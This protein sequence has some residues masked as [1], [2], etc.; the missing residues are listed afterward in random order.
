[1]RKIR[2]AET[3]AVRRRWATLTTALVCAA[4]TWAG[5][6]AARALPAPAAAPVSVAGIAAPA[7]GPVSPALITTTAHPGNRIAL[8]FDDGPSPQ[9]TPQLLQ[10]LKKHQ[11]KAVFCVVGEQVEWQ[12]AQVRAIVA[13]GHTLCNH[14]Y[15]HRDLTSVSS[16]EI[17]ADIVRTNAQIRSAVPGVEIPYFRAPY[18]NW[19]QSPAVAANLGLRPLS[20]TLMPGDW[21]LPGVDVL[22]QRLRD[23]ITPTGVITLHD[24]GGDRQQTVDAVDRL[25]TEYTAKGWSFDLPAR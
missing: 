9:F 17:E 19:G 18:G 21:E 23:G 22:L 8:T 1:M 7:V 15:G 10:V 6:P 2:T 20:W 11:V 12:Q 13:D 24:A 25:I 4:T 16:T 14:T 5:A 3:R